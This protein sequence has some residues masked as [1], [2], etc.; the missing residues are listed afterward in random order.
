MIILTIMT[1]IT[2]VC[3][4]I[5]DRIDARMHD[6]D[7]QPVSSAVLLNQL[8]RTLDQ[9]EAVQCLELQRLRLLIERE[10]T[11]ASTLSLENAV[12]QARSADVTVRPSRAA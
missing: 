6:S 11:A 8:Q 3:S 12:S 4:L 5:P 7:R 1:I 10:Q 2:D 9:L